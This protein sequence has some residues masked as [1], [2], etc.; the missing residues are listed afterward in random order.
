L[1]WDNDND[2]DFD[3]VIYSPA[4]R[5]METAMLMCQGLKIDEQFQWIDNRIYN[6]AASELELLLVVSMRKMKMYCWLIIIQ[7]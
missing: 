4:V 2:I 7:G 1:L 3:S 5:T 6:A